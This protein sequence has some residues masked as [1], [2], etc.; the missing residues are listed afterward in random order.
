MKDIAGKVLKK[1]VGE[2]TS[3]ELSDLVDHGSGVAKAEA[4]K[5][6]AKQQGGEGSEDIYGRKAGS[7]WEEPTRKAW[8]RYQELRN[9]T[10]VAEDTQLAINIK[11]AK[12]AGDKA[13]LAKLKSQKE[14]LDNLHR[15]LGQ[16]GDDARIMED[17]RSLRKK[18][19]GKASWDE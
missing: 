15:R 6:V 9:S 12:D 18:V 7:D 17:I 8:E 13:T 10:D 19:L 5:G 4:A 14:A 16:G 2:M 1:R 3:E 11:R